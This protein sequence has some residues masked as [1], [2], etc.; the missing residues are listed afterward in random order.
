MKAKIEGKGMKDKKERR[1]SLE[2]QGR[3]KKKA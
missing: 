1:L 2:E 3:R